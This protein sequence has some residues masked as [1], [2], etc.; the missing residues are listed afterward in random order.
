MADINADANFCAPPPGFDSEHQVIALGQPHDPDSPSGDQDGD[1]GHSHSEISP[2]ADRRYLIIAIALLGGFMIGEVVVAAFA[3][4]LALLAD[5]GHMLSD[6]GAI[7]G[8][9]WAIRLMAKPAF[10][11]WTFGFQRAEILSA[12]VNGVVLLAVAAVVAVEGIQHLFSPPDVRGGLVLIVA[13]VGMVVNVLATVALSRANRQSLNVEGAF[14][15]V[16]TDLYAFIGTAVAAVIILTTGFTRADSI[17]SLLVAALMIKAS[18]GLL[19]DSGRILLEAAPAG[20]ALDQVRD[21][22]LELP[23]VVAIHDLHVWTVRSGLPTLSAH[24]VI[25][26]ECFTN[27]VAPAL[28][29]RVQDCLHGHFDVE[30]STLQL[31]PAG[32]FAHESGA[33]G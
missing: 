25:T 29:D 30:H 10:G 19:R 16:L 11:R 4:S 31:E 1:H 15:H 6:V 33:H 17:A 8:A 21:H 7:A 28:L 18:W 12:A 32:H 5:A 20:M 3:D 23:G 2:D 24:V 13:L 9:L 26:D 14:Q 22:I 27:G